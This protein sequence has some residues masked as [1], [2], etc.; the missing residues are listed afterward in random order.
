ME[1]TLYKLEKI[2]EKALAEHYFEGLKKFRDE[3]HS[4]ESLEAALAEYEGLKGNTYF[5]WARTAVLDKVDEVNDNYGVKLSFSWDEIHEL[6]ERLETR[7]YELCY[8]ND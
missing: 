1:I 4:G 3:K 8:E 5:E 7:V 2:D 6:K